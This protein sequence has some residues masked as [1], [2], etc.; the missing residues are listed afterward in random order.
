[1]FKIFF[2]LNSLFI[3]LLQ[4][5]QTNTNLNKRILL[6]KY[7]Q[8]FICNNWENMQNQIFN[9]N[10]NNITFQIGN[11][12]VMVNATEMA[13]PFS[14]SP[15]EYLRLPSTRK[16][17]EAV[18]GKSRI[19][20]N[21]LVRTLR[22]GNIQGT[23]IHEDIALDFAQWLSVDFKLWC[24]DRIKELLKHG[25]TAT[26]GTIEDLLNN[27][28]TLIKTLEV[29]K[30]ER[31]EKER[32][33]IQN[34][35]QQ[36]AL[37]LSA[38]KVE[39]YNEV[40]SSTSTYTTT[41]IAKEL[42]VS[43]TALNRRLNELKIQYKQNEVWV[44]YQKYHNRGF[45]KTTTTTYTDSQGVTRTSMLTVWTEAGRFFIHELLKEKQSA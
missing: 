11:G 34:Q 44:L 1:M 36:E 38:P 43:A 16:L 40:L 31:A 5:K 18:M 14:K 27:P 8:G 15:S 20:E 19:D 3:Y 23:W 2:Y 41:L 25:L 28:D 12:D 22:G 24:N 35:K 39:Y 6:L 33:Q 37:Q 17:I 26:S 13:K 7:S 45:T 29:L 32:L 9:Y 42:G 10:G 21:Q 30:S 4:R